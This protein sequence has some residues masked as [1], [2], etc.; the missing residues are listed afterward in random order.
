L[1]DHDDEPKGL[2]QDNDLKRRMLEVEIEQNWRRLLAG[3]RVYVWKFHLAQDRDSIEMISREVLQDVVVT[4][5]EKS[6]NYNPDRVA[7]AW[8]L[9]VA[10]NHVRHRLRAQASKHRVT[11]VGDSVIARKTEDSTAKSLSE[12]ELLDLLFQARSKPFRQGALTFD[13]MLS[14]APDSDQKILRLVFIE[15]LRGKALAAELR[16]SEGA[17]YTRTSRAIA[18][19]RKA[20]LQAE[21]ATNK[22][23]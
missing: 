23:N 11:L 12:D 22:G 2:S 7:H 3:I 6:R 17:A 9:R 14:L 5:L 20:Y 19:L 13:E 15:N 18:N 16:I 8:L 21:Q 10:F 1:T 4:A